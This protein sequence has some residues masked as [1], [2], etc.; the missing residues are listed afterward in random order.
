MINSI[1]EN[2]EIEFKDNKDR[3]DNFNKDKHKY[4]LK[5]QLKLLR[6]NHIKIL[7]LVLINNHQI[8]IE[9]ALTLKILNQDNIQSL[10]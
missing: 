5:N 3:K 8:K 7:P 10:G 2:K 1:I 9:V 6:N 4:G